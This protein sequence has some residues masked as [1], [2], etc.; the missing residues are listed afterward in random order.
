VTPRGRT[1]PDPYFDDGQV[2]LYHGD[3]REVLPQFGSPSRLTI[4]PDLTV[5]DPPYG[6]TS[7]GWDSWPTGWLDPVA[8]MC[9]SMWCFGSMRMLGTHWAELDRLWNFSQDVVWRKQNGSG[10]NRDR[11][12]RV[13]EHVTHWYRGGWNLI[14]HDTPKVKATAEQI[15]K[16]GSAMR[17]SRPQHWGDSAPGTWREDGTRLMPSVIDAPNCHGRA[18]HPTEKPLEILVPLIEY[19]CPPGGLILDPFAGSCST[20]VAARLTGRRAIG[21]EADEAMCEKAVTQRLAQGAL[22]LGGPDA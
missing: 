20:L 19:G 4:A 7:L 9:Q 14:H 17:T 11:F 2:T 8:D 21:I 12:R 1:A 6:E 15:A 22:Q 10:F 13:H 18:I 16:N 5:A 3:C